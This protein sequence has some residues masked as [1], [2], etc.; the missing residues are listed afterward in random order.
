MKSLPRAWWT[1]VVLVGVFAVGVLFDRY[2]MP[3][4]S[5][6]V[7]VWVI[8][9]VDGRGCEVSTQSTLFRFGWAVDGT[10]GVYKI[11]CDDFGFASETAAL[12]CRC[13]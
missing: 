10:N 13:R 4:L 6:D 12:M 8:P 3:F 5:R 1:V 7:W 9:G 11:S 2:V